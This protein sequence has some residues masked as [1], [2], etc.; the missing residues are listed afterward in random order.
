MSPSAITSGWPGSV[1]SGSTAMRPAR[2]SSAP[3][4]SAS[5]AGQSRR[6]HARGPDRPS[7]RR[8][9]RSRRP[10][11]A[12]VTASASMPTTVRVEHRRD[13]EPLERALAPCAT[14]TA[15]SREHAV[16]RLDEQDARRGAGR[17]RGSRAAACRGR[18][19]AIWPAIS[20]PVGPGADDHERQPGARGAPG[21]SRSRRA[22]NAREDAARAPRARSRAT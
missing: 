2:S 1:R 7:A 15:G 12:T 14:A 6:G 16:G 18:A 20:T 9:A 21:R 11:S 13:A 22:S 5:C 10:A 17:S 4:S 19:R 3:V 8:C